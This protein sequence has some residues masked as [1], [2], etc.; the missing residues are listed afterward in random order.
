R[1]TDD[2][3]F[4][5]K[6]RFSWRKWDRWLKR[7]GYPGYLSP[8]SGQFTEVR[9]VK[10]R[11]GGWRW[12]SFTKTQYASDPACGG[13]P[14][15]LRCHIS[16]VTLLDRIA[17]LPTLKVQMDDEGRYGP[18]HYSDDWREAHAEGREPTYR[19]HEGKYVPKALAEEVGEWNGMIAAFT[20]AMNDLLESPGS[21]SAG[22]SPIQNFPNFEQLEFRG[23]QDGNVKPFLQVMAQLA[24]QERAKQQSNVA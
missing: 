6:W 18:S 17:E 15:F 10:T 9:K 2:Q 14:N 11:L 13:I 19:W 16:V 23:S 3:R 1:P 5:E 7:N 22:E 12:S 8:N 21:E 24:E 20:G 4:H